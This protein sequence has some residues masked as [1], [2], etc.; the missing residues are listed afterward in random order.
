MKRRYKENV[1]GSKGVLSDTAVCLQALTQFFQTHDWKT[2]RE[3]PNVNHGHCGSSVITNMPLTVDVDNR[4]GS[5]YTEAG[6]GNSVLCAQ[7]T[8]TLKLL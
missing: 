2:P 8:V 1:S 6:K 5:V 4:E 7:C 3:N